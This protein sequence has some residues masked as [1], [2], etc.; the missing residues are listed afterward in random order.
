MLDMKD[1]VN[2][3]E[4]ELKVHLEQISLEIFKLKSELSATRKLPRPHLLK[5]KKKDRARILT[6]LNKKQ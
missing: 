2:Q 5:D 1:L 4:A 3:T 6:A